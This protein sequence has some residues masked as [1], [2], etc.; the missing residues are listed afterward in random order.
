MPPSWGARLL[1]LKFGAR[2][3]E[4]SFLLA[5]VDRPILG[6]DFLRANG[7]FVDLQGSQL[8]DSST[9]SPLPASTSSPATSTSQL[10]TAL[11][12]APDV[13]RDLLAEFPDIVGSGFSDLKPTHGVKHYINT[14][15]QPVFAKARRL[16]PDKLAIARAEFQKMEDAGIIRRV[17]L[18]P[19]YHLGG[20]TAPFMCSSYC[21]HA[22]PTVNTAPP[23]V[24]TAAPTV[25]NYKRRS[26]FSR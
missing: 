1:P 9:M 24:N 12:S 23:T 8:L 21:K 5:K 3:F 2:R 26:L 19:R 20:P 18:C 14:K 22:L 7:L 15:G 16:D 13:V 10:Y 11:L 4:W 17:V 25:N 6:A